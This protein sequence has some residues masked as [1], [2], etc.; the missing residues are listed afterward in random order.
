MTNGLEEDLETQRKGIVMILWFDPKFGFGGGMKERPASRLRQTTSIRVAALHICT[1]KTVQSRFSR[2][3]F[4]AAPVRAR[5][6]IHLGKSFA[7][8]G[9]RFCS[10]EL[11]V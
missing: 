10:D 5:I 7:V 6:R 9:T 8:F 3:F 1:P 4:E 2:F 11:L